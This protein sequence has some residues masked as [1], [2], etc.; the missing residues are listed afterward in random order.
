VKKTARK[1]NGV[2]VVRKATGLSQQKFGTALGVSKAT[3]ENIELGRAPVSP[4]LA[5]AIGAFTGAV[6]WTIS[7]KD[8]P[9][10]FN[11]RPYSAESWKQWQEYQFND[12]QIQKLA[13][14]AH[15]HLFILLDAAARN[16]LREAARNVLSEPSARNMAGLQSS[17]IFRSVMLE[18]NRFIFAQRDKHQLESRINTLMQDNFSTVQEGETTVGEIRPELQDSPQ[19]KANEKPQWKPSTKVRYKEQ[20]IP[21]F[22][23]FFG[24]LKFDDGTPIFVNTRRE[25]RYIYDLDIEGHKF[26]VVKNKAK[27][28]AMAPRDFMLA[29][30]PPSSGRRKR[31][32]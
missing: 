12:E 23:P 24:F 5:D 21:E 25:V 26:R 27:I 1:L 4:E 18:F 15:D 14:I 8:G 2:A 3:I 16:I 13:K 31:K 22:V 17:H 7:S 30:T 10:D 32:V 19:W 11:G 28:E 9:R 29:E 20:S 6:P